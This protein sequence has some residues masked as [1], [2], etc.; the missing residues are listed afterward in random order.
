MALEPTDVN[1]KEILENSLTMIKEKAMKNGIELSTDIHGIPETLTAD[2][3]MLKQIIYNLLSNAVKFT[4]EGGR[5]C[6]MS[7]KVTSDKRQ[8]MNP[9]SPETQKLKIETKDFIEISVTDTGIGLR[10]ENIDRIFEPFEQVEN[11]ASRKYQG[12]GLGLSLTKTLVELHGGRLWAESTG[13]GK[14]SRF[15]FVI[16]A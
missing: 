6:L 14:G 5:I 13:E 1:L 12:T 16:P 15:S 3:R 2:E 7:K 9:G 8:M 11:S 4:P 10:P